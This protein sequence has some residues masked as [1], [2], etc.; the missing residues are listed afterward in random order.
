MLLSSIETEERQPMKYI[1]Y[2]F[3]YMY[4]VY[5]TITI[6]IT[7]QFIVVLAY[8][9]EKLLENIEFLNRN[10]ASQTENKRRDWHTRSTTLNVENLIASMSRIQL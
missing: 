7:Y 3:I 4:N 1:L 8:D 2:T 6:T 9:F 10:Y 5:V